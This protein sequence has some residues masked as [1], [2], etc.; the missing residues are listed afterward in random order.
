M[1]SAEERFLDRGRDGQK[2]MRWR[3]VHTRNEALDCRVYGLGAL[4]VMFDDWRRCVTKEDETE[5]A[6]GWGEFWGVGEERLRE[7]GTANAGRK[8]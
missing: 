3:K 7:R 1:L 6:H 8:D 5:Q 4:Y 2:I